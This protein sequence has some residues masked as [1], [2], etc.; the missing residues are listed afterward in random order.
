MEAEKQQQPTKL[1]TK[2]GVGVQQSLDVKS[3]LD[4]QTSSSGETTTKKPEDTKKSPPPS[5]LT[6]FKQSLEKYA[7]QA[8]PK[9]LTKHGIDPE[10]F[11]MIVMNEVKRNQ[12]L[13]EAFSA[14]PSSMFGAIIMGAEIGLIPSSAI[15]E[16]W[17]IPRKLKGVLTV[18]P[19]IGYKGL[20]SILMRS[21]EISRIHVQP[22]FKGEKFM[23]I[24]GLTPNIIH[25]KDDSV[26]RSQM[27]ITHIYAVAKLTNGEF[28]FVVLSR[29]E[30]QAIIDKSPFENDLIWSDK[31]D[32]QAWMVRK[33]A[34]VQLGKL[35][36]KDFYGK[37]AIEM[38]GRIQGGEIITI[39]ED[40][41][42]MFK[43]LENKKLQQPKLSLSNLPELE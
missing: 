29:K 43:T 26:D 21:G 40:G 6:V 34:L 20:H 9:L 5:A 30:L 19:Q 8:L 39:D 10:Q 33:I 18:C 32:P 15:G 13:L 35:L 17:L 12:G 36:P 25:E 28:Q 42:P 7:V 23:E 41:N 38:D 2:P 16:F 27:H 24:Q 1:A 3:D 14:N 37:K 4:V 31:K 11:Y 22:V